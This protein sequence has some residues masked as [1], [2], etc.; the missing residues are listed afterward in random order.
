M[1]L[2]ASSLVEDAKVW[3]DRCPKGCIKNPEKLQKA[4]GIRWCDSEHSQDSF[5]QCLGICK[6]S[7]EGIIDFSDMFNLLLKRVRSKVGSEQDILY[8]FL[9]SLEGDFQFKIRDR[10]PAT[11]EEAQDLAFQIEK[12]FEFEDYIHQMDFSQNFDLWDL[13]NKLVMEPKSPRILQVE[14]IPTK[15]KWSLSRKRITSSQE[16]P[17]KKIPPKDEIE[18]VLPENI[19][20]NTSKEFS[21][22][23]HQVGHPF[24]KIGE[25][26]P[27]YVTLQVKDSLLHNYLLHPSATTNMMTEE[28]MYQLGLSLS[29]TNT[30]GDFA[31]GIINNLEVSFNSCPDAP[32]LINVVVIDVVNNLGIILH[33]HL[34]EHLNGS[35]H[36]Q[37]SKATIPNP[38][39]GL[40]TIYDEPLIGSLVETSNEPS[41][42]LLCIN[43]GL[44]NWFVQEGK[45]VVDA[46][47]ETK[48]IWTSEFDGSHS[49][50]RSGAG[51]VLTTPSGEVLYHSYRLEF[52]CTNN[53]VEYEALI[54]GLNL[55]IDKGV[56]ILEVK[57]DSDL[58]V[59]QVLMRFST[60]N[61]KL[62]KYRDVAQTLSKSFRKVS[63]KVVP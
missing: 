39:G 37:Q 60:K 61:E 57:G 45:L 59:S 41:D 12:N 51:V 3:I 18:I 42:Q 21:L 47:E 46:I 34:I 28:V 50:S 4:F 10:S 13:G 22:F 8:H 62:K 6:G 33:K 27:F 63:I 23:I 1:R 11:L 9:S 35:I 52:R 38:E 40:F 26:T 31:K 53:V 32:Y 16:P 49:S 43:S 55:A 7:C 54:L 36:K 58:I 17:L 48:G 30:K 14:P 15:I 2:F 44:N 19:E 5:S 25:F 56:T 29:Q 24:S 20:Q